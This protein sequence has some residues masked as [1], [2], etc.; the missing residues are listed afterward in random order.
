MQRTT[1]IYVK[2]VNGNFQRLDLFNDETISIT[3]KIQDVRDIAK[4]FTEFSQSFSVPASKANN[5]IFKHYYNADIVD[6]FD[7]RKRIDA[8][9][10]IN[11]IP[12]KDGKI[13]LQGVN[14]K[15]NSPE[16][17]RITFFGNTVK[18]KDI[19]GDD[20]LGDL[21]FPTSLNYSYDAATVKSRLS[22]DP[23]TN[24]IIAPLITHTQ[25]IFFNSST[26]HENDPGAE[27]NI[28]YD[29]GTG[30]NHGV[31]WDDIKYAIRVDR[32]IQ[33]IEAQYDEISF[34]NDFFDSSNTHYYGLFMW[35]H[36]NKGYVE[37]DKTTQTIS[38]TWTSSDEFASEMVNSTTLEITVPSTYITD[39][40]LRLVRSTTES[41]DVSI[42]KNGEEVYGELNV[43][44]TTKNI[45]F[46][47]FVQDEGDRFQV[48]ITSNSNITFTSVQ[49]IIDWA[50]DFDSG[51]DT[52][53]TSYSFSYAF[54]FNVNFQMPKMKVID[55]LSGIFKMFNLTAFVQGDGTI[56]VDT[57]D[58]F[59]V[60]MQSPEGPYEIDEYVDSTKHTVD[61]AL[62]YKN[63]KFTY[64]DLGT[65]FAIKHEQIILSGGGTKWGEEDFVRT[66]KGNQVFSGDDYTVE[67]PFQHMKFERLLDI[68]D[69]GQTLIQ[70]GYSADDNFDESTGYYDSYIGKPLL[71][72]PVN[73]TLNT[74]NN[75]SYVTS[76]D[77]DDGS[78]DAHEPIS[79]S[80][81]VPSNSR[82]LLASTS[83]ENINFKNER[84]E[85]TNTLEF[86]ETLF[87]QFYSSYITQVFTKSNR[88]IKLKAFLP[89]KILLNYT[90][91][92]KF[93]YKGRKHQIN[94]ITTNLN[95]GESEIELLNIVIE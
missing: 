63:V 29:S 59:Y 71:F 83:K 30:H 47:D 23:S 41:Y 21:N 54:Q 40:D 69:D 91:A 48:N 27:N 10:Q 68:K 67:I 7:G 90:L 80:I 8:S 52:H 49:W 18:L 32:I 33:Q 26:G 73:V 43:T 31:R 70:W 95:T 77:P 84:N 86:T 34:S 78:F 50:F 74:F 39:A 53:S 14:M 93:I 60:D 81:N 62:P 36:R 38:G 87:D 19:L 85:Y 51:T 6:G 88:I 45:D 75:V 25:R 42:L 15:D 28:Y 82:A 44:A 79:T 72:Y 89:L 37:R 24:D 4:V 57:L 76:I 35:M 13:T 12:F 1:Q 11:N 65:L 55:F 20:E 16:S 66:Y 58:E 61:S 17:Y 2:D 46:R 64:E 5:K 92:D 3:D 94:S 22:A 9:I 56:Y